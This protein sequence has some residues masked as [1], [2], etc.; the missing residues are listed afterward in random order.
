MGQWRWRRGGVVR[1]VNEVER[2]GKGGGGFF[3]QFFRR[4]DL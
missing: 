1:L 3:D 4:V 2:V